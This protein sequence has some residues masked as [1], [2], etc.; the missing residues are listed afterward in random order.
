M[1]RY[2][3]VV[4]RYTTII[5]IMSGGIAHWRVQV[6][7]ERTVLAAL[8]LVIIRKAC[9]NLGSAS[10]QGPNEW[11][12]SLKFYSRPLPQPPAEARARLPSIVP[13]E[14]ALVRTRLFT[15]DPRPR[16]R[17]LHVE[18]INNPD[19]ICI[20]DGHHIWHLG[21]RPPDTLYALEAL[22]H[23]SIVSRT[24]ASR[25]EVGSIGTGDPGH[26]ATR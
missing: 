23:T 21:G 16:D 4:H 8:S 25:M 12:V 1:D 18:Y 14:D 20:T 13:S 3:C 19:T 11:L 5:S 6:H 26:A 15:S 9:K 24:L 10:L 17:S 2:P 22:V 7:V